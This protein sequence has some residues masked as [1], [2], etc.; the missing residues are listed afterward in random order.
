MALI[1]WEMQGWEVVNCN[2]NWGCP[3]Q[4]NQLPSHGNCSAYL[5][6]HIERGHFGDVRLD[7]LRWGLIAAW[8]GAIHQGRGTSRAVVDERGDAKQRAAL[9][10]VALGRE[11][12]PMKVVWS[13]FAAMTSTFLPTIAAP[14]DLTADF[15]SRMATVR[16]PGLVHGDLSP[17]TNATTGAASRVRVA[18]PNGFEF[19][20]AEFASG[21]GKVTGEIPMDFTKTHGHL[22]HVHWNTQGVVRPSA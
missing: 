10:A 22:A 17:I 8:P 18:L 21:T 2:C 7:G 1:Q 19:L 5:F 12:E 4:F 15:E 20:E 11:T 13:V 16:V 9:E 14:I 3:C 6:T